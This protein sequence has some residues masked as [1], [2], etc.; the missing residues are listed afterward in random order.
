MVIEKEK[1]NKNCTVLLPTNE[2]CRQ[3]NREILNTI[4]GDII[5]LPAKDTVVKKI[6]NSKANIN[7]S[8]ENRIKQLEEDPRNTAGLE[9]NLLLKPNCKVML[10]RNID[11]NQGL[12]NG[13]IGTFKELIKER[14]EIAKLRIDFNGTSHDIPRSTSDFFLWE[15]NQNFKVKR[16][17]FPITLSYC[18]TTHKSQGLTLD[19]AIID[20]GETNFAASQIYVAMSR[21]KTASSL[22]LLNI[23]RDRMNPHPEAVQE[24]VRL[25]RKSGYPIPAVNNRKRKNKVDKAQ[26]DQVYIIKKPKVVPLQDT[27]FEQGKKNNNIQ[28]GRFINEG[29]LSYANSTL[30]C[31]LN[32]LPN[33]FFKNNLLLKRML[34]KHNKNA[35]QSTKSVRTLIGHHLTNDDYSI[36]PSQ[37]LSQLLPLLSAETQFEI[38]LEKSTY[39]TTCKQNKNQTEK[40]IHIYTHYIQILTNLNPKL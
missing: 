37:F 7:K 1:E 15:N 29:N 30:Q 8:L 16:T 6:F 13:T 18:I 17:Q 36:C 40:K 33:N 10:R 25:K 35:T 24:E 27:L 23:S 20:C 38:K 4:E 28:I 14:D 34:D 26:K 32:I 22:I 12:C 9:K 3:V 19:Y 11:L 39:C 5:N 2:A 31:F 21:V